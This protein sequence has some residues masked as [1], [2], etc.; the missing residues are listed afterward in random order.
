MLIMCTHKKQSIQQRGEKDGAI[1]FEFFQ[2]LMTRCLKKQNYKTIINAI[3]C[4][5]LNINVINAFL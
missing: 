1:T 2:V 4:L 3:T 5:H